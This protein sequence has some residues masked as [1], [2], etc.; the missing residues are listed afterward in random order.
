M[1]LQTNSY[2]VPKDKRNEHARLIRRFRQSLAKL[3]C[4]HFEV[5]EQVSQNWGGQ[6]SGGRYVQIMRFRDRRHQL[7]VQAAERADTAAQALIQEFCELINFPFQQQQGLFAVGFYTSVLPSASSRDPASFTERA[8]P[9]TAPQEAEAAQAEPADAPEEAPSEQETSH[10]IVEDQAK[11]LRAA[12]RANG[13][14]KGR[15]S[16]EPI[17]FDSTP[18]DIAEA[19]SPPTGPKLASDE[20]DSGL[21]DLSDSRLM[22]LPDL[23]HP[24]ESEES[25]ES[26][27]VVETPVQPTGTSHMRLAQDVV[28]DS[29]LELFDPEDE[30]LMPFDEPPASF[31]LR[32]GSQHE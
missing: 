28:E 4:D 11:G 14:V 10:P 27:A 9:A 6:D 7:E 8:V 21:T 32:R 22:D 2:V 1:L 15:G 30:D 24:E 12:V 19:P 20:L 3:G 31:P 17:F 26:S 16:V 29:D 18:A 23:D 25:E 13:E 5:Y